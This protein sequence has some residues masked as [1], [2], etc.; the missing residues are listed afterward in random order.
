[1]IGAMPIWAAVLLIVLMVMCLAFCI[2]IPAFA[3]AES[4]EIIEEC[5][6]IQRGENL[7]K[8]NE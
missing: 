3:I 6:A 4:F 8:G 5:K 2:A 7:D 1:M